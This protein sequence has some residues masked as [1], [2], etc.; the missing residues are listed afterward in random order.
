LGDISTLHQFPKL[1]KHP[2]SA[3]IRRMADAKG[4]TPSP[5]A[6]VLATA[7]T[8]AVLQTARQKIVDQIARL[9]QSA[10]DE[11]KGTQI[12]SAILQMIGTLEAAANQLAAV[13]ASVQALASGTEAIKANADILP[14]ATKQ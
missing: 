10:T 5:T 12:E 3:T 14:T 7:R 4:R 6:T 1:K 9:E 2:A 13:G 8:A 11:G